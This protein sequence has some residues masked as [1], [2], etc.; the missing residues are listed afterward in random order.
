MKSSHIFL[1]IKTLLLIFLQ[2]WVFNGIYL[3]RYATPYP[4]VLLLLLLPVKTSSSICTLWGGCVGLIID[5]LS[6]IPGL[7]TGAFAA[8]G[9]LRNTLLHPFID[10]DT[11]QDLSVM[12]LKHKIRV[13]IYLL[14]VII[15]HHIILF[16]LDSFS[17]FKLSYLLIRLSSSIL[18]TFLVAEVLLLLV[19][20]NRKES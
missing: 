6:G 12:H 4:Y 10:T 5:T 2:V 8:T 1:I 15:V 18:L 16:S 20:R 9:F 11:N 7:N 13:H 19:E 3:F 14:F 17:A